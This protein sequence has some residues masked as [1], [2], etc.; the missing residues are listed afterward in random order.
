[1]SLVVGHLKSLRVQ[2]DE[3]DDDGGQGP[4][5][6]EV[7]DETDLEQGGWAGTGGSR[8]RGQSQTF[9]QLPPLLSLV[10]YRSSI[11]AIWRPVE[12]V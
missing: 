4:G 10:E 1:M 2:E 9:R 6:Q 11:E 12:E 5:H 7:G 8:N 3:Q